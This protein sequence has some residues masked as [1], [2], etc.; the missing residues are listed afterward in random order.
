MATTM[1]KEAEAKKWVDEVN[2]YIEETNTL[3]QKVKDCIA[4]IR[5]ESKGPMVEALTQVAAGMADWFS[6]LVSSLNEL[7]EALNKVIST[8]KK[9]ASEMAAGIVEMGKQILNGINVS[10]NLD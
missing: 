5:S 2:G 10:V 6:K 7:V 3:L 1:F 9:A 4:E 8:F